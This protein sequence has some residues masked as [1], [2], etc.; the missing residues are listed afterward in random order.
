MIDGPSMGGPRPPSEDMTTDNTVAEIKPA[1]GTALGI[2]LD[3]QP[4]AAIARTV[5]RQS[6]AMTGATVREVLRS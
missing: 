6:G 2:E 4:S 3:R 1:G 5:A